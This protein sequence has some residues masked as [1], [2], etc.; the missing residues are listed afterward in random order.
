MKAKAIVFPE[1]GRAVVEELEM[2]PLGEQD[3]LVEVEYTSISIG[4]ERWCLS[5][6]LAVPGQPTLEFPHVPGYQAAGVVLETGG[7][8]RNLR[9]G[10]RVFS[11]NCR[12]PV[13]WPGSWWGGHVGLHVAEES[14]VIK[15]PDSVSTREASSL[16]LAQ[17]GYN[18]ASKPKVAPGD[19][20]VVIGEGLVGQFAAQVL[21]N[22]GARVII[23]GLLAHRLELARRFSA[24]EI[25]DSGDGDLAE[26][27]RERYPEGVAIAL[28]TASSN[29]TV[30]QAIDLLQYGGQLVLNG[31]YP[32]PE[33]HLDWH[34]LRTK[35]LTVYCPNSRTRTRLEAT[36]DL[37]DR[38]V[39]RVAELVT[40]DFQL[41]Q[42]PE[43]YR[44]LLAPEPDFLGMVIHWREN[45][46]L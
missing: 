11:R 23:S 17:V 29:H 12:A 26:F 8:V 42:A 14:N 22:R 1:P 40:H 36:L 16:L 28:D 37:M 30:C 39:I 19:V 27:I 4:T 2:P 41:V 32:P 13:N 43:A 44:K 38:G 18:G 33:S 9:Q 6:R 25:F 21:R 5:G 20:A 7:Q 35:E 34:W 15:L 31:F 3:V 24:D 10:D 45:S 46:I